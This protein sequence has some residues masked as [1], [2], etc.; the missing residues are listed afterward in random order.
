M[1][2][3]IEERADTT[4]C[5]MKFSRISS[6]GLFFV[7]KVCENFQSITSESIEF[8]FY[9]GPNDKWL[10]CLLGASTL[11]LCVR[12]IFMADEIAADALLC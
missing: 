8:Q 9:Y 2:D 12:S 3:R 11:F 7:G 6:N 5:R 4:E 1:G 10:M